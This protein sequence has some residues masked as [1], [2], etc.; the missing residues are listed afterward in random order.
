M[1]IY[2]DCLKAAGRPSLYSVMS[3]KADP[4]KLP[5]EPPR[6]VVSPDAL[7]ALHAIDPAGYCSPGHGS[8]WVEMPE[9]GAGIFFIRVGV[10]GGGEEMVM[11]RQFHVDN[12]KLR[13]S[14]DGLQIVPGEVVLTHGRECDEDEH[15]FVVVCRQIMKALDDPASCGVRVVD[16]GD[17]WHEVVM[18]SA[19]N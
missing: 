18:A 3:T 15:A 11:P 14:G 13:I 10:R 17:G 6:F 4:K 5:E 19:I 1:S 2:S 12:G 7:D 8:V 16:V 9:R